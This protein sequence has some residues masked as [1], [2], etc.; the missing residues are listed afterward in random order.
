[1]RKK[2]WLILALACVVLISVFL[3]R[4]RIEKIILE[5][6]LPGEWTLLAGGGFDTCKFNLDG[7]VKITESSETEPYV[8]TWHLENAN[9]AQR[10][11]FWSHPDVILVIGIEQY[12]IE[13]NLNSSLDGLYIDGK[14]VYTSL[15]SFT[16]SITFGEGGGQYVRPY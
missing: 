3:F 2:K 13:L 14:K 9:S 1:M 5:K 12:G 11:R 8:A 7:T 4:G 15:L 10:Q 6:T 16:F